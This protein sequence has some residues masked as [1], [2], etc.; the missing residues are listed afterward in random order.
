MSFVSQYSL[1]K[2]KATIYG[3]R[4]NKEAFLVHYTHILLVSE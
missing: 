1:A 2:I 3:Q 4:K